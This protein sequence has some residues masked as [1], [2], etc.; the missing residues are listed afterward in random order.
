M[1]QSLP[2]G[3]DCPLINLKSAS[4]S[5]LYETGHKANLATRI[6]TVRA[7]RST[8]A[9]NKRYHGNVFSGALEETKMPVLLL[10]AVPAVI[11]VG[12]VSYYLVRA[13][14]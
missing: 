6:P 2:L 11:V 1:A 8:L 10:W 9:G 5:R 13:V 4:R 14:N 3:F 7:S 12:G